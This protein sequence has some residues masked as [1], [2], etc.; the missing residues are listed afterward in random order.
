MHLFPLEEFQASF[1]ASERVQDFLEVDSWVTE[2]C[3]SSV[4]WQLVCY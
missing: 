1:T 4:A 2:K 3:H